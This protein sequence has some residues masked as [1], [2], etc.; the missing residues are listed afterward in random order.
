V[1]LKIAKTSLSDF[2]AGHGTVGQVEQPLYAIDWP[3]QRFCTIR[4][5]K[6]NTGIIFVGNPGTAVDGFA[7]AA[8]D[9]VS[10]PVEQLG[11]IRVI[12]DTDNQNYSWV[13]A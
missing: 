7:M 10:I 1:S 6:T 8:G 9:S 11:L 13:L 12:A 4:A 5:A 3:I 2:R